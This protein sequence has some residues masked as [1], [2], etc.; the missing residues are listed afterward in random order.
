M[1]VTGVEEGQ[2]WAYWSIQL[3]VSRADAGIKVD[4]RSSSYSHFTCLHFLQT[5]TCEYQ[6]GNFVRSPEVEFQIYTVQSID[7]T[8]YCQVIMNTYLI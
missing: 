7:A 2:A 8:Q 1:P 3:N 5:V 4:I 6:Q